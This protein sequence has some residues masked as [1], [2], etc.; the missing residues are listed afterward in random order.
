MTTEYEK[1][2]SQVDGALA[3][4]V[5]RA[6]YD[7]Q[8]ATAK[9]YPRSIKQFMNNALE[10]ATL[11]E[12]VAQ[13][14]IYALP[15]SGKNIEG[16]SARFAEMVLHS[17]GHC[18]AGARVVSEDGRFV[19]A[20]GVCHDLQSNTLIAYEVK[21]RITDSKG[22]RYNDDMIGVTANAASSIALR[23]AILKVI[24][25]VFWSS[26]YDA[27]RKTVVGDSKTLANRRADALSYLQNFGATEAM[28]LNKL[29]L[30]GV[31]DITLD[32]L[33]L[34]RGMATALKD[35]ESTVEQMFSDA[36]E[37]KP[38]ANTIIDNINKAAK[39]KPV[40]ETINQ[41]TGEVLPAFTVE[42]RDISTK[43]KLL[44]VT[45]DFI[46]HLASLPQDQRSSAFVAASG[47]DIIDAL[48]TKSLQG[49][50]QKFK[51]LGIMI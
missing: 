34:L 10:M 27:A 28:V 41:E 8:I 5:T 16:P 51:D 50:F 17:W 21:R 26:I 22:K 43:D 6:E 37:S 4:L 32:H 25:K 2:S 7:V 20:Q 9:K 47:S 3:E 44:K 11:N 40:T 45:D 39:G 19:T 48:E 13:G 36:K 30:K 46:K 14:C 33:L 1:E 35:G 24:P 29:G 31:E 12:E 49:E 38:E 18:R 23:N 15:R 42:G